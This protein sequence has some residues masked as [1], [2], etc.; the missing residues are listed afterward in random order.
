MESDTT[1]YRRLEI[2][3]EEGGLSAPQFDVA[4][5]VL[6]DNLDATAA[7]NV[8]ASNPD[9][10]RQSGFPKLFLF[11][12]I[13]T[14]IT[15]V[16]TLLYFNRYDRDGANVPSKSTVKIPAAASIDRQA[17]KPVKIAPKD[18]VLSWCHMGTCSWWRDSQTSLILTSGADKLFR[19]SMIGGQSDMDVTSSAND[20]DK[21]TWNAQRHEVFVLCSTK[22]PA[23]SVEGQSPVFL[24]I[25][26]TDSIPNILTSDF[27][28]YSA[29]CVPESAKVSD[30]NDLAVKFG[31][32]VSE[33]EANAWSELIPTRDALIEFLK[34]GSA[35][36]PS[37]DIEVQGPADSQ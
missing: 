10:N 7:K 21:V 12:A 34:T 14:T 27:A 15:V 33:E 22:M 30:E 23:I 4:A 3:R 18:V 37:S 6:R 13:I 28:V 19:V 26:S 20:F 11:F 5:K 8:G 16:G 29:F 24:A 35:S 31:Y 1:L 17:E 36:T 25:N 9:R 32:D 2:L